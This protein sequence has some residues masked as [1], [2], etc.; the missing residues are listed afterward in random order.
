VNK[1]SLLVAFLTAILIGGLLLVAIRVSTAKASTEVT[2]IISSNITWTQSGS[3][4]ILT[5]NVPVNNGVTLTIEPGV[6]VNIGRGVHLQIDG[7]LDARGT[8]T[9]NIHLSGGGDIILTPSSTNWN[10]QNAS[11][12]TIENSI[13]DGV[14]ITVCNSA[15]IDNNTI[16]G[17]VYVGG[18]SPQIT[19]NSMAGQILLNGS[20]L[21]PL[22]S[23]NNILG[24]VMIDGG[25]PTISQ[26]FIVGVNPPY[27]IN[28]PQSMCSAIVLVG[29][30]GSPSPL[31]NAVI[32]DNTIAAALDGISWL[33]E[34]GII[35]NNLIA[36]CARTALALGNTALVQNNTLVNSTVG[37]NLFNFNNMESYGKSPTPPTIT[38][39][40]VLNSGN[41]NIYSYC[42]MN[43]T[44]DYNWWGTTDP[45]SIKQTIY[46]H[47][48]DAALGTISYMPFLTAPNQLAYPNAKFANPV[49]I[50]L[51]TQ[52]YGNSTSLIPFMQTGSNDNTTSKPPTN[53]TLSNQTTEANYFSIESNSTVSALSF[54]GPNSEISF[55]V[56]GTTGTMGYV[57]VTISK[58]FMPNGENI[59]V[60]LDGDQINYTLTSSENSWIILF[61]YH[62]SSHQVRINQAQ[63]SNITTSVGNEYLIY[64]AAFV[65]ALIGTLTFIIRLTRKKRRSAQHAA[66]FRV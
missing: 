35:E 11:G 37:I 2:G 49:S 46:D 12:T 44:A 33:S 30:N 47:S 41:Y 3:P 7:T 29:A 58:V 63:N 13:V 64:T 45:S 8:N 38:G 40:N 16:F 27:S 62:H 39:N 18:G 52:T 21:Y 6:T 54:N 57:K 65:T 17:Y 5:G 59:K 1:K 43:L 32:K 55:T 26:N 24:S 9:D 66:C 20:S 10:Q 23:N 51:S 31:C 56:N 19:W 14:S 25:S 48:F 61:I 53:T 50:S 15:K 36:S 34:G 60:Y 4:Y 42:G 28:N 22:I